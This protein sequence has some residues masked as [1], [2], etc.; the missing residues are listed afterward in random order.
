[1]WGGGSSGGGGPLSVGR[2]GAGRGGGGPKVKQ[3]PDPLPLPPPR[4]RGEFFLF[5]IFSTP[6]MPAATVVVTAVRTCT[7]EQAESAGLKCAY[8][9]SVR[10]SHSAIRPNLLT[11]YYP[12]RWGPQV[13]RSSDG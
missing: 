11:A 6:L 2:G 12:G 10:S 3:N 4:G 13:H 8:M 1:G 9:R 7:A 5:S